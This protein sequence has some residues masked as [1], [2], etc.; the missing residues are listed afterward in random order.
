MSS[1]W[2]LSKLAH[3]VFTQNT[4]GLI[5]FPSLLSVIISTTRYLNQLVMLRNIDVISFPG[6]HVKINVCMY[7]VTD[8]QYL[9]CSVFKRTS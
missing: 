6:L 3:N 7:Q 8:R 4:N 9:I 5:Y 2:L 1:P